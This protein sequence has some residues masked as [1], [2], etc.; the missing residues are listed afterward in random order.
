MEGAKRKEFIGMDA[1][2]LGHPIFLGG[3]TAA[4]ALEPSIAEDH[5]GSAAYSVGS[6]TPAIANASRRALQVGQTPQ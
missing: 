6:T 1:P 4:K 3:N 2:Q 5:S